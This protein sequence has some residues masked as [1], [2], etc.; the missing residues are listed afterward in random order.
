MKKLLSL[1]AILIFIAGCTTTD[2]DTVTSNQNWKEYLQTDGIYFAPYGQIAAMYIR[3]YED[4]SVISATMMEGP[5]KVLETFDKDSTT[6]HGYITKVKNGMVEFFTESPEAKVDY[7]VM[8]LGNRMMAKSFSHTTDKESFREYVFIPFGFDFSQI[9]QKETPK[10]AVDPVTQ[11][12]LK[13]ILNPTMDEVGDSV[14]LENDRFTVT[15][16]PD[17]A[18]Q[19]VDK[20]TEEI[21]VGRRGFMMNM[22]F[23]D[24]KSYYF[25]LDDLKDMS[26]DEFLNFDYQNAA[27][28][29]LVPVEVTDTN[30]IYKVER[31][32]FLTEETL[33]FNHRV[34][35]KE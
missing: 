13:H 15:L 20:D 2:S 8:A 3:V 7:S 27:E 31:G 35:P 19:W 22:D 11:L 23:S 1:F 9:E 6:S 30:L 12:Y 28:L 18:F 17:M 24:P 14:V 26:K 5:D 25:F 34:L 29:L 4:G 21:R 32:G 10:P 33:S 16:Q